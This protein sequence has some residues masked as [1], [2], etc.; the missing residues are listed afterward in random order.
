[1]TVLNRGY[2]NLIFSDE[3]GVDSTMAVDIMPHHSVERVWFEIRQDNNDLL[4]PLAKK[5]VAPLVSLLIDFMFEVN[6]D[7]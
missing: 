3:I 1:M 6:P 2:R 7:E 5:D 4:F